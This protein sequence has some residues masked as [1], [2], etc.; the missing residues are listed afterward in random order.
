MRKNLTTRERI[1]GALAAALLAACGSSAQPTP[2]APAAPVE[3][4]PQQ[5]QPKAAAVAAEPTAAP[6]PA[7]APT[8][9]PAASAGGDSLLDR[10]TGAKKAQSFTTRSTMQVTG[11]ILGAGAGATPVTTF[12]REQTYAGANSRTLTRS[13][14]AGEDKATA[15]EMR[16]IDGKTYMKGML[17]TNDADAEQWLMLPGDQSAAQQSAPV[18]AQQAIDSLTTNPEEAAGYAKIGTESMDGLTCDV[19]STQKSNMAT[20]GLMSAYSEQFEKVDKAEVRVV[21][22]PDGRMHQ[23]KI[24]IVG[25]SKNSPGTPASFVFETRMFDFDKDVKIEAPEKVME[26]PTP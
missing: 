10:L 16:V 12:E 20:I 6:A 3:A 1:V 23:M 2:T 14:T 5:E 7:E 26:M 18:D 24:E 19:F 9:A 13:R 17:G 22:C 8:E 25:T 11:D 4:Q 21:M 15:A